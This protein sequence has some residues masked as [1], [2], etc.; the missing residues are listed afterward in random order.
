MTRDIV[1]HVGTE[2][3]GSTSVQRCLFEHRESLLGQHVLYPESFGVGPH[4]RLTACCVDYHE[5]SALLRAV[6]VNSAAALATHIRT[7]R[8]SLVSE[9]NRTN[10]DRVFFSDEHIN[11]HLSSIE[12]LTRLR[13]FCEEIGTVSN[14]VIYI[15]RQDYFLASMMSEA[16]KNAVFFAYNARDPIHTFHVIPYRFDYERILN[17][18]ERSFPNSR[19]TVRGYPECPGFDVVEDICNIAHLSIPITA[20]KKVRHNQSLSGTACQF[21]L[22]VGALATRRGEN[23]LLARWREVVSLACEVSQGPAIDL[24]D[25]QRHEFLSRFKAMNV[26]LVDR[27]PT[28]EKVLLEGVARS[29]LHHRQDTPNQLSIQDLCATIGDQLP[30]ELSRA[31]VRIADELARCEDPYQV[32]FPADVNARWQL[33]REKNTRSV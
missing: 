7:T 26:R 20:L 22:L 29:Q 30:T 21:L 32:A 3:T 28:L 18:I 11:V 2:K 12:R 1:L 13:E 16:V 19:L 25:V 31:L 8:A 27:Y 5:D 15:R 33:L 17:N 14:V 4:I 9:V 6:Q 23:K 10:P 24:T